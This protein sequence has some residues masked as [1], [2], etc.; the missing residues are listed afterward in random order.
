M[1]AQQFQ[2][3]QRGKTMSKAYADARQD[4]EDEH[5]HEEGYSG[6]INSTHNCFDVTKQ[7]KDS[8]KSL[9]KFIDDAQE[10]MDKGECLGICIEEPTINSNKIKSQVENTPTI[11][12]TKWILQYVVYVYDGAVKSFNTKGDAIKFARDYTEKTQKRTRIDMEKVL[13]KGNCTVAS[14][15]YKQSKDEKSGKYV[16]FGLAPC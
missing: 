3:T 9:Q 7:Y 8:K 2:T 11:G 16:F 1:G 12:T 10:N 4:A 15:T 6:E 5:G 13:E 14:V